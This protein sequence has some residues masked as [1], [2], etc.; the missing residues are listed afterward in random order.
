MSLMK[1]QLPLQR[2]LTAC[3]TTLLFWSMLPTAFAGGEDARVASKAPV[4]FTYDHAFSTAAVSDEESENNEA[5]I[6]CVLV[7]SLVVQA[8]DV[9]S[10]L[11]A[12]GGLHRAA[13]S[14]RAP[15]QHL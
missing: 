11:P 6:G 12:H 7:S 9:A 8:T 15:P 13:Y 4:A 5:C 2:I 3:L 1:D 10:L 14:I